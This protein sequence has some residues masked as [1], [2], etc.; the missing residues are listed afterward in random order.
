MLCIS[1][2]VNHAGAQ[3]KYKASVVPSQINK[4]EYATLRLEIDNSSSV[5]QFRPPSFKDFNVV[6]GPNQEMGSTSVNGVS[7]VYMAISYV[8]QPKHAGKFTL[9]ESAIM[10]SGKEYKCGS[11]N[12]TVRNE[13]G[14]T[15]S[16]QAP[17]PL[18]S[19][20]MDVPPPAA[21]PRENYTD[22][23]L[24]QGENV[25]EKVSR[26]MQLRVETNKT[27]CYVGE[28]VV[29]T[30]KLYT[31]LK[32]ESKMTKA[33]SFNG[34]SVIDLMKPDESEESREKL[35]GRE[36]NV[37]TVRK[38]QLYP[39]QDGNIELETATLDNR[40]VFIKDG[41]GAQR[42]I[43]SFFN[44]YPVDP[45]SVINQ[46]VSLSN[47]PL[48]INVKPLPDAGKPAGFNG[49]VGKFE[50]T[51]M[52]E[53]NTFGS[54]ESGKL[55]VTIYGAGN[56]Q[57]VTAPEVHWPQGMKPSMQKCRMNMKPLPYR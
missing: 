33:P 48:S 2:L 12:L 31:R 39:L 13:S 44:G 22:Y 38:S 27:S 25:A 42:N 45:E 40:I 18:S 54:D 49:A 26:N 3:V 14:R 15:K 23:I 56:L 32:S 6:S 16:G 9:G 11:V 24:K 35:N 50:I 10:V 36:Y 53:K 19:L 1:L 41:N 29:A 57:L 51:A 47:K 17:P 7:R 37:Y 55:M 46:T 21:A 52:L 30:Y 20:F 4:D 43:E 8:L 34:F 28:P 5:Q